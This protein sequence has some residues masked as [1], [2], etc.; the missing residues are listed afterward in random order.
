MNVCGG[1][2]TSGQLIKGSFQTVFLFTV[3][4]TLLVLFR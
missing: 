2:L 3:N 1:S 4:V